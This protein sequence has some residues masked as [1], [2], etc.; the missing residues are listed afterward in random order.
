MPAPITPEQAAQIRRLFRPGAG[1]AVARVV[2]CSDSTVYLYADRAAGD[3]TNHTAGNR[4]AASRFR[5]PTAAAGRL[6]AAGY[7]TADVALKLG[8]PYGTAANRIRRYYQALDVP[9]E[10]WHRRGQRPQLA[11]AA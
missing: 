7:S 3:A 11:A 4:A 9:R 2:G 5:T 6:H 10:V 1:P 8:I